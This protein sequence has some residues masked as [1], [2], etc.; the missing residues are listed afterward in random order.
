VDAAAATVGHD[1]CQWVFTRYVERLVP[2][3]PAAP[4]HPNARGMRAVGELLAGA[5]R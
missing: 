5:V 3:L 2:V 4:I 1:V